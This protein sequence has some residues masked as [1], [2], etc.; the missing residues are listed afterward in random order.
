MATALLAPC[1]PLR[2]RFYVWLVWINNV[3]GYNVRSFINKRLSNTLSRSICFLS[4]PDR[5]TLNLGCHFAP[6]LARAGLPEPARHCSVI[7]RMFGVFELHMT[8]LLKRDSLIALS[9]IKRKRVKR[10][11]F[12]FLSKCRVDEKQEGSPGA[13]REANTH[14]LSSKTITNINTN[15]TMLCVLSKTIKTRLESSNKTR[16]FLKSKDSRFWP[17]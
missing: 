11:A 15:N 2:S 16:K 12:C 9:P 6:V 14:R 3:S 17:H 8:F 13:L 10:P 4:F 1:Q 7:K 5:T